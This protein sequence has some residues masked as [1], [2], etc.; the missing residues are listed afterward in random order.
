MKRS[1]IK[2]RSLTG[3]RE[4]AGSSIPSQCLRKFALSL[5]DQPESVKKV[6]NWASVIKLRSVYR[7]GTWKKLLGP[8]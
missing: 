7:S 3:R 1:C 5:G 6:A 2:T 8:F 4:A